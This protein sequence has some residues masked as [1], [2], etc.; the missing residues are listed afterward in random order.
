MG[1]TRRQLSKKISHYFSKN[2]DTTIYK[3]AHLIL[4]L[5]KNVITKHGTKKVTEVG[6][7]LFN[8]NS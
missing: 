3:M 5:P 7:A 2:L 6:F 4:S 8:K 1:E